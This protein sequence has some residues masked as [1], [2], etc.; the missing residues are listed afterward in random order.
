MSFH[1]IMKE[2]LADIRSCTICAKS[3]PYAPRPLIQ[4]S[5]TS[6]ILIIGQ[7]PGEKA[8]Q[9]GKLWADASGNKLRSWLGINEAEFYN[10]RLFALMPM[11]FCFPGKSRSGDLPPRPECAGTWH[12]RLMDTM[13]QVQLTILIGAYAQKYYLQ[14]HMHRTLTATVR[15]YSSFLPKYLPLPHPSPRNNIWLKKNPWFESSVLPILKDNVHNI[16]HK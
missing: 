2:L 7:A 8:Q 11:G 13:D 6:R 14:S 15:N 16:I 5:A 12:H 3:L 4:A 1:S 9:E 10:D